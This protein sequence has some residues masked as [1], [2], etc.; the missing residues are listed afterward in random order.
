[1]RKLLFLLLVL[2]LFACRGERPCSA[3]DLLSR[4]ARI[5]PATGVARYEV[6]VPG[7]PPHEEIVE[8]G[9]GWWRMPSLYSFTVK[10]G[11]VLIVEEGRDDAY[12]SL[13]AGDDLQGAIDAAFEN[14]GS[15]VIPAPLLLHRGEPAARAFRT[16]MLQDLRVTGCQPNEVTFA[17]KNG[18][19]VAHFD[20]RLTGFEA[21]IEPGITATAR[22]EPKPLTPPRIEPRGRAVTRI[23]ELSAKPTRVTML[24][25]VT[26]TALDGTKVALRDFR[27][28]PV[29]LEFWA[30]WCAPCRVQ[31]PEVAKLAPEQRVVLVNVGDDAATA[32]RYLGQLGIHLP[33]LLDQ[34][35][36]LHRAFGGGLPLQVR[37]DAE[38]RIVETR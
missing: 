26:L 8:Y 21:R 22:F 28:A 33:T 37:F 14:R 19:I 20:G 9:D 11:R 6:R 25:D 34:D 32:R 13:P 30:T 5:A 29:I 17:A 3:D 2:P 35:G 15:P 16:K 31:L 36:S 7:A 12:V 27:G 1:M 38:G 4:A 10:D 23:S 24:P 18:S